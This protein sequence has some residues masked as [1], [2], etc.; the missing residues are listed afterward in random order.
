MSFSCHNCSRMGIAHCVVWELQSVLGNT[1]GPVWEPHSVFSK[2]GTMSCFEKSQ[3]FVW[4]RQMSFLVTTQCLVWERQIK[5]L[6]VHVFSLFDCCRIIWPAYRIVSTLLDQLRSLSVK[7]CNVHQYTVNICKPSVTNSHNIIG[8]FLGVGRS[9]T[10]RPLSLKHYETPIFW[11]MCISDY[12]PLWAI[13]LERFEFFLSAVMESYRADT[14]KKN[15]SSRPA[16]VSP[17]L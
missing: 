1:R 2:Q 13:Q 7:E 3:Y 4:E 10:D 5:V 17:V 15:R 16:L 14:A 11:I 6:W 8:G 12:I 9:Q